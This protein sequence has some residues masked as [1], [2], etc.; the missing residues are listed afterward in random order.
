MH[1]PQHR[2]RGISRSI[3]LS[4]CSF[5]GMRGAACLVDDGADARRVLVEDDLR[6]EALVGEVGLC[7][8][9][10]VCHDRQDG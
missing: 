7:F 6:D 3:L 9:L 10:C 5:R 2:R 1:H 8:F 4:F